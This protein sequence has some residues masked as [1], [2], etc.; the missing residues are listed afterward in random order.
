MMLILGE[1]IKKSAYN[2]LHLHEAK[3]ILL[4]LLKNS[5]I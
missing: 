4:S 1:S 5:V 3:D 2:N